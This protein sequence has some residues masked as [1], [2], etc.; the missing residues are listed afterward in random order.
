MAD[1][2]VP[3][4]TAQELVALALMGGMPTKMRAGKATKLPPPATAFN[5]P[6]MAPARKRRM[7]W[8][9]G[10]RQ[11]SRRGASFGDKRGTSASF[12]RACGQECPHAHG[13]CLD[14]QECPYLHGSCLDGQ[15]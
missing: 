13:S 5:A 4:Q 9:K 3:G 6:A 11:D 1:A 14:G 2:T 7:A 8:S 12:A 15:E 10:K